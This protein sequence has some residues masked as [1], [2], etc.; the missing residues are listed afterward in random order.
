[1]QLFSLFL[2]ILVLYLFF[3][4]KVKTDKI[5]VASLYS[6]NI[7]YTAVPQSLKIKNL[8]NARI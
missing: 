5:S 3:V 6:P 2:H 4:S 7:F 1:M 8:K